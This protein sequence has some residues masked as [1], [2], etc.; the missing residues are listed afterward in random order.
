MQST[1]RY[2]GKFYQNSSGRPPRQP[3]TKVCG[4]LFRLTQR[5][6]SVALALAE[7]LHANR[8]DAVLADR[9]SWKKVEKILHQSF[10]IFMELCGLL[11]SKYPRLIAQLVF[12][13]D[14]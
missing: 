10:L 2:F 8:Y 4:E 1:H 5:D 3:Q 14:G 6:P 9:E 7:A 12:V 13:S 11:R